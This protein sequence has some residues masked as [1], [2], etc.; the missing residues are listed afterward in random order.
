MTFI[1]KYPNLFVKS[2]MFLL[3]VR[4]KFFLM[5]T[6]IHPGLTQLLAPGSSDNRYMVFFFNLKVFLMI[7]VRIG[8]GPYSAGS[9]NLFWELLAR[10]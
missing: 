10:S 1:A 7:T 4:V 8:S 6:R 9:T 2:K 5:I 3:V